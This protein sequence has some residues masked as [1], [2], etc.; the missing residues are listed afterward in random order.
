MFL[1]GDVC[2]Y[3]CRGGYDHKSSPSLPWKMLPLHLFYKQVRV[4]TSLHSILPDIISIT[5]RKSIEVSIINSELPQH[6]AV[7]DTAGNSCDLQQKCWFAYSCELHF[8]RV[9]NIWVACLSVASI[10]YHSIKT[11]FLILSHFRC[12]NGPCTVYI[13]TQ[14]YQNQH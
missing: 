6:S 12:Q 8:G 11:P 4:N 5:Q 7:I 14:F 2:G 10:K 9:P 13:L 1:S 3:W